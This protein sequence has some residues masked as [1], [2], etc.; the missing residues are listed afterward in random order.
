VTFFPPELPSRLWKSSSLLS[1]EHRVVIY[2]RQSGRS[3]DPTT[4]SHFSYSYKSLNVLQLSALPYR[5][6]ENICA[7]KGDGKARDSVN[8][9]ATCYWSDGPGIPVQAR[10]FAPV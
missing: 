9:I 1:S 10:F 6:K 4:P 2:Q 7:L 8:G 5:K 3:A